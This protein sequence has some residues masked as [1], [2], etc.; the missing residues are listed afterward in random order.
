MKKWITLFYLVIIMIPLAFANTSASSGQENKGQDA[1]GIMNADLLWKLGRVNNVI[2]S[3]DGKQVVFGITR[4]DLEANSGQN[5]LYILNIQDKTQTALTST[6]DKS[7]VNA[8]WRPDGKKIGYLSPDDNN[9]MQLFEMNPD[10]SNKTK[11]STIKGG[12]NGFEYSP[13]MDHIVYIKDV[14][15]DPTAQEIHPDLPNANARIID[16]LMYRHWDQWHD[17]KYSHVFYASYNGEELSNHT[18]IM[19]EEPYDSPLNPWGGMEQITWSPDGKKIAYVSKKMSPKEYTLSTN[20]EIY[21]YNIDSKTTENL[22]QDGFEGFDRNPVF[23]PNGKMIAWESMEEDGFESDKERIIIKN[24]ETGKI[25]N[26][27]KNFDQNAHGYAWNK[28]GSKLYFISGINATYQIYALELKT[29]K[30]KQITSGKHNYLNVSVAA[31]GT[32]IG[33]KQAMDFPTE[34]FKIQ[35]NG[36]EKQLS[37]VNDKLLKNVTMAKSEER[38]IETTDGK[39]MLVWVIFPPNFDHHKKYPALLYAQ[40]GPQSAVSQFFSY[41]WN[42]Q[43]MAAHDYIIV[44]PNRRGLPSFGEEWN[45]QISGDYGGQNIKDYM[46]AINTIAEEPYVDNDNIG[47]IGA[48]YGGFSVFYLA[49]KHPESFDCFISHCGMFNLESQYGGTEEYWFVNKDLEGPYWQKPKP[50]SYSEFSPHLYVDNWDTPIMIITGANDFR[51]PY[52]ESLQAF[53]AAQLRDVPSKLLFFP[54]ESHFV[55]KPQNSVL[56]HR[57]FFKWLDK[58]LKE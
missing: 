55:L 53:N 46:T 42:F 26:M 5:D 43:M 47:A 24:L 49:G 33:A 48:S 14:K 27:S 51:I 15:L 3:P 44:A 12:I 6:T 17:Y 31:G 45:D 29:E 23:S 52:T 56:W 32:L 2:V 28:D 54:D 7:E 11:V 34:I 36:Q 41:R 4:Y 20:S 38:W 50:K 57:E 8:R 25:M 19:A 58:Y 16:N 30:F 21:L 1:T 13:T 35:A 37:H 22:T 40:G 10:G 9:E 39:K 18:D